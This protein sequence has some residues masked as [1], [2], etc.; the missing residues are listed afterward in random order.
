MLQKLID[1]VEAKFGRKISYQKDCKSLS[2]SIYEHTSQVISPSTLR[3]VFGFLSTNSNPSRVTLDILSEYCGFHNWDNFRDSI[4]SQSTVEPIVDLWVKAKT[5]AE[6]ISAK[7]CRSIKNENRIGISNT[8]S[9]EFANER[10]ALFFESDHTAIPFIGPGGF[11][12]TTLLQNWYDS[13]IAEEENQNNILLFI[14]AIHL[15][16]WIGKDIYI[17][18]WLLSILEIPDTNLFGLLNKNPN[19]ALGKFV[20]IIDALDEIDM[21]QAKTERIF[22]A[23]HQLVANQLGKWFKLIVSSRYSTWIQF[24][25]NSYASEK[26]QFANAESISSAG[27][28]MP[29]LNELEIQQILDYTINKNNQRVLVEE[30][31]FELTQI[32]SYPYYLELFIVT[33]NSEGAH[34]INDRLDLVM[35][36]IKKQVYQAQFSDEKSDILNAIVSQSM[37]N[38]AYSTIKKNSLK[39]QYPIHLKLAGDYYNAYNQLVSFGIISEE[40][41]ENQFGVITKFVRIPQI[42]LYRALALLNIIDNFGGISF[43]LF[44]HIDEEF[45]DSALQP[46]LINQLF[47]LAYKRKLI[48]ALKPFFTLSE[49]T[50]SKAFEYPNIH[51][52]LSCDEFMRRELIPY[53]AS[54]P[55]ARKHLFEGY[56]NINTIANSSRLFYF[57]Y[58]QHST[59]ERDQ[60]IGKTLLFTSNTYCLDFNWIEQFSQELSTILP[61]FNLPPIVSG[62]W[63]SCKIIEKFIKGESNSSTINQ[64]IE[65]YIEG[66]VEL[67]S[68]KERTNFELALVFGL[69]SAKQ[70]DLIYNRIKLIL[71]KKTHSQFSQEEKALSVYFELA[72]WHLTS[73][74]DD[75]SIQ[76]VIQNLSDIPQWITYQTTIVGKS[77]LAMYYFT[78]GQ[79]EKAYENFKKAVEISNHNG[80]TIFEVKLLKSLASILHSIGEL[81]RAEECLAFS[82]SL[83]ENNNIDFGSL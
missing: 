13:F 15:E 75:N 7:N 49:Q 10:L 50:L 11:G 31:P 3:R 83:A 26:W 46:H 74:F 25:N 36:F 72:K 70:Y 78:R 34:L 45:L 30:L 60:F 12:K 52:A 48:D 56:I 17:E 57:N 37:K 27:I 73:R 47:E 67:W 44:K 68:N 71:D 76:K 40:L 80:Y 24:T 54:K 23:I 64:E 21:N 42:A 5:R 16:T 20:L 53:Y 2:E 63:F 62:Q 19:L 38:G 1:S 9:R 79:L 65:T 6:E 55:E 43:K 61:S 58:I 28:N 32:I 22:D 39:E 82:K 14:P 33:F 35:E 41:T 4:S 81:Q 29:Y 77:V 69:L 59:K 66:Q 18:D 51:T 8:V